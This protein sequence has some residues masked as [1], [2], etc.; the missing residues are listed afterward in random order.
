M[1]LVHAWTDIAR[2]CR[3]LELTTVREDARDR[4]HAGVQQLHP[5]VTQADT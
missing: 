1:S 2:E 3:E 5:F 4:R